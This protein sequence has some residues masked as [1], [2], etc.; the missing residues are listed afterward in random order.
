MKIFCNNNKFVNTAIGACQLYTKDGI[1]F[2]C[3]NL[4]GQE[5]NT[6]RC[7]YVS[8]VDA[9]DVQ[10]RLVP[11]DIRREFHFVI[12]QSAEMDQ[13]QLQRIGSAFSTLVAQMQNSPNTFFNVTFWG[14]RLITL[15]TQAQPVNANNREEA[16]LYLREMSPNL[17]TAHI[18]VA[19]N[20]MLMSPPQQQVT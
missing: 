12:E 7:T 6:G 1:E 8:H 16:I 15:W 2:E 13:A 11:T 4:P 20:S 5:G 19:L 3:G 9:V 18:E 10:Q 17:G 14:T